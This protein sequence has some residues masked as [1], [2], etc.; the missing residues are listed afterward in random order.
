MS[1][2]Q[3]ALERAI[4]ILNSIGAKYYITAADKST[5]GDFPTVANKSRTSYVHHYQGKVNTLGVGDVLT[6]DV[7]EGVSTEGLRSTA[8]AA[9]I[10]LYGVGSTI[11]AVAGK[12]IEILRVF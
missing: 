6:L 11:S 9:A 3:L 7:P 12:K 5:Y 10:K 8:Q 1:V 4:T 2:K